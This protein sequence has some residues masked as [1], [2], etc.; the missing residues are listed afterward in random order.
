MAK[1]MVNEA[2]ELNK[3]TEY[4]R[5]EGNKTIIGGNMEIDGN[6]SVNGTAPGGGGHMYALL[7]GNQS[8]YSFC[9]MV[10]IAEEATNATDLITKWKAESHSNYISAFGDGSSGL[11]MGLNLS[12]LS[13]PTVNGVMRSTEGVWSESFSLGSCII[14]KIY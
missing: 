13:T 6:L 9:A 2:E 7:N 14:Y 11:V 3:L 4:V 5:Q 12:S 1:R 8:T 10:P